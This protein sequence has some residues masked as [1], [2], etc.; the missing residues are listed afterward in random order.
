[1]D[2]EQVGAVDFRVDAPVATGL[3]A[4]EFVA[5]VRDLMRAK[6]VPA[7]VAAR[8]LTARIPALAVDAV[9]EL[10]LDG[11]AYRAANRDS[12]ERRTRMQVVHGEGR[13]DPHNAVEDSSG[14]LPAVPFV[15]MPLKEKVLA[16]LDDVQLYVGGERKAL[17]QFTLGDW[18]TFRDDSQAR[19][20]GE[21]KRACIA[22]MALRLLDTH[23][24]ETTAALPK[25]ALHE[26]ASAASEVWS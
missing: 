3:T 17:R 5:E 20:T 12:H 18:T 15:G 16:V 26:L 8:R 4:D 6:G 11:A 22:T 21:R 1:M 25:K 7:S 23:G 9:E 19:A 13:V 2:A 14:S 10:L 24:V